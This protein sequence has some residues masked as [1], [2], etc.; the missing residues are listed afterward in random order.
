MND[1]DFC[2]QQITAI[3]EQAGADPKGKVT[4]FLEK[5]MPAE[6]AHRSALRAW[7]MGQLICFDGVAG[8]GVSSLVSHH[9]LAQTSRRMTALQTVI[10]EIDAF[11]RE[12]G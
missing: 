4:E 10:N 5:R 12:P 8:E 3:A 6:A 1:L 2:K 7:A 11:E 9:E